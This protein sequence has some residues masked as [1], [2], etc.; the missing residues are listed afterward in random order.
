MSSQEK[1]AFF[2]AE[3]RDKFD[4]LPDVHIINT[5]TKNGTFTNVNGE[6][7]INA[8]E[9]DSLSISFVGYKNI[10][11]VV[12]KQHFGIKRNVIY[13][14]KK[15]IDLNEVEIRK[16]DLIGSLA[17]DSKLVKHEKQIDAETLD[18]PFAGIP[19][20]TV[21]ERRLY[22]A[23]NGMPSAVMFT[24]FG[25]I[26]SPDYM[27]NIISGR[28]KKLRKLK[29]IE[30]LES[31]VKKLKQSYTHYI[32]GELN[33]NEDHVYQFI[34]FLAQDRGFKLELQ[35]GEFAVIEFIKSKSLEF[36]K[37]KSDFYNKNTT[38]GG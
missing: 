21:A 28:I 2:F 20:L 32:I 33:I 14:E 37:L 12:K 17:S 22:T 38:L 8:K 36:K 4:F 19:K 34:Y 26:M 5:Q 13:L 1:R 23:T 31:L 3:I 29:D 25:F 7:K 15:S 6:F 27:L 35:K 30:D 9:N 24:G 11:W 18:L 16:T 10:T